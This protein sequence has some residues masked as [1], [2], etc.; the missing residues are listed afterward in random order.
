V[1]LQHPRCPRLC[2]YIRLNL[3]WNSFYIARKFNAEFS[4]SF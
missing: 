1:V 4:G 2:E 3:Y